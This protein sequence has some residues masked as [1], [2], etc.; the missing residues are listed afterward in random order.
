MASGLR[1]AKIVATL[2]PATDRE[3]EM[4][5]MILAGLD[6][7]RI[8]MS[9]G[10]P[11]EHIGRA[12]RVRELAEKYDRQVGVLVDLQGPKIR[13][14][15][16]RDG[17]IMLKEGDKFALDNNV[18]KYEGNQNEVGLTYKNLPYDCKAGNRLLL[19]DGRIVMDVDS[20]E[21]ERVNCTV[22]VGGK[23][24]N[25]KGINLM[26]GGLSAAALTE[27]D[28][29]DIL[30][31]A[32]INCDYLALSFP[33]SAEDVEECRALAEKAGLF[34]S[35]VSKVER[36]EAVADD[37]TLDGI[38]LASDV[39]MIARGDLGVEVGDAQLPALQK[40]MIKRARQ[41]NRVTITA[42]QMMETMI[43]NAIP[44]RAEVFDV[45]NAVMDGTDAVMLSGETAVGHSPSLVIKTMGEICREAEKSRSTRESTHRIDESFTAVDETIAMAA[46]YAANH[47]NVSCIAALT[48]SGNTPLLMSR[49]SSG[50]PIVALTPHLATRRKVTMYRGVYPSTVDYTGLT[51]EEVQTSIINQLKYRNIVKSGDT[52]LI[53]RGQ[54]RGAMGGTNQLEIVKVP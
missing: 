30:T 45:A 32:K 37:F 15:R 17:F 3:G 49:I 6:V 53:T 38:I 26:G 52:M 41:L 50:I 7:V 29:E 46:M 21:G 16:F 42:T 19:D 51:D 8:N 12:N 10:E 9:H 54:A 23:L 11:E 24:S 35:I 44:T 14:T 2:G 36:A 13:I 25:N 47:F 1:R 33:R 31:A 20:V 18:D 40:K 5:K 39:I 34:C 4:E 22:V 48:E 27:K 43:D 28:K